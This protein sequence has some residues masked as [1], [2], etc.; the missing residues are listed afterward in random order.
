MVPADDAAVSATG[1]KVFVTVETTGAAVPTTGASG[2]AEGLADRRHRASDRRQGLDR[3]I[4][5]QRWGSVTVAGA[6]AAAVVTGAAGLVAESACVPVFVTADT[7]EVAAPVTGARA[8][9]GVDGAT[10]ALWAGAGSPRTLRRGP[11]RGRRGAWHVTG[12]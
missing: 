12:R 9:V 10:A 6:D 3:R 8:L 11:V 7:A 5:G 1:V 4:G 2:C